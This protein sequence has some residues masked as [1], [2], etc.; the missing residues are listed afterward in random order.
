MEAAI[1]ALLTSHAKQRKELCA[2]REAVTTMC[3][4]LSKTRDTIDPGRVLTKQT[5][6][7]DVEAY[8]EVFERTAIREK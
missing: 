2:L 7:D 5:P 4:V 3:Q 8:L 6:D 1:N